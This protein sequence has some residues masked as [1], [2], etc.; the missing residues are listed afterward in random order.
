MHVPDAGHSAFEPG[1]THEP[2]SATDRF[3]DMTSKTL[4]RQRQHRQRGHDCSG[5]VF[6]RA[7]RIE[8]VGFGLPAS[9]PSRHRR[10]RPP[11][12]AWDD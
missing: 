2:I 6:V 11:P 4:H 1:I 9:R 7:G 8:R 5:D 3:A 12:A 10:A